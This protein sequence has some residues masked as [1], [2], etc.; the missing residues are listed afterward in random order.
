MRK[1]A[2]TQP[3]ARLTTGNSVSCLIKESDLRAS[4]CQA[5]PRGLNWH[6]AKRQQGSTFHLRPTGVELGSTKRST[7]QSLRPDP[8]STC[9]RLAR[10][11]RVWAHH[12][13]KAPR[14][15]DW[16]AEKT[17]NS[18]SSL[19]AETHSLPDDNNPLSLSRGERGQNQC[20]R[21]VDK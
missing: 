2:P 19:V 6:V 13:C 18:P 16:F 20:C 10:E 11:K 12:N 21:G 4:D 8:D 17:E 3:S 7:R 9:G 14:N 1:T 15:S 5:S